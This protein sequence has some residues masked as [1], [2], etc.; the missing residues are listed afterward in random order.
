MIG[1]IGKKIGMTQVFAADNSQIGVTAIEAGPCPVLMV[2]DKNVQLGFDAVKEKSLKKAQ[3]GLYKKL[4]ITPRKVIKDLSKE[5]GV[6]YK[7][8]DELKVDLFT[9]GDFV[10]VSGI[11]IGKGFAG[12]MKRWHWKGGPRTHGSTSHRRVGSIGSSTTPGR[13]FRGHHMPGHMGAKKA[14]V[15][16]LKIIKIDLANNLLLVEGGVPGHKNGYLV[17]TKAIKK[18]PKKAAVKK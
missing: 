3:L 8:G 9:E 16:N 4:N 2:M 7:V 12:G 13:V 6:E 11:S 15:Q 18:R 17:I 14:T 1:L 5:V 10:D